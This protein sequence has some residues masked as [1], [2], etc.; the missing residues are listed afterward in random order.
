MKVIE[1]DDVAK[2][3]AEEVASCNI[4]KL[5]IGAPSHGIFTWYS[6]YV[7]EEYAAFSLTLSVYLS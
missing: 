3:I 1:S 4:N 2:A 5:V 7:L 6:S